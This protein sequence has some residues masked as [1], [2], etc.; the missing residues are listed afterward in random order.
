MNDTKYIAIVDDHTMV[1]RGLSALIGLFPGYE[2]VLEAGNGR[3]LIKSMNNSD[4]LPHILLLDIAMPEMDGYSTAAW[5]TEHYPE[6]RI[7]A[8]STMEAEAAIL[9]MIRA[10]A[11]GYLHKDAE[12]A[13][14]KQAFGEVFSIGY[15]YNEY[16][17][18]RTVKAVSL[19]GSKDEIHGGLAKLTDREREFLQLACSEKTYY[20]IAGEMFVSERTVD[21]YRDSLFKKLQVT[22][23]VGL[24]LYAFKNGL[25]KL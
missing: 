19:L 6:I 15:Y 22:T 23:R 1:R 7:L 20:D 9:R 3:E 13:D 18:R 17:S 21:G 14:L 16:V 8:L 4:R 24:A 2:V 5:M 10:G 25:V 11:R 12:P